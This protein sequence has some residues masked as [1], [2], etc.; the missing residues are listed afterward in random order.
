M[1][2]TRKSLQ[3]F[4]GRALAIWSHVSIR[5]K[6][7]CAVALLV[8]VL[9][10]IFSEGLMAVAMQDDDNWATKMVDNIVHNQTGVR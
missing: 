3:P 8:V 9:A 5:T 1:S 10:I 7:F 6:I 2:P 4:R